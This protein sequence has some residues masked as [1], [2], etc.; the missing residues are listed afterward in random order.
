MPTQSTRP[1]VHTSREVD[2]YPEAAGQSFK[3]GDLLTLAS[4]Q[5]AASAGGAATNLLIA[6]SDATG[7]TNNLT[8]CYRLDEDSRIELNLVGTL[9]ATDV[10]VGYGVSN[11]SGNILQILKSDTT[12]VRLRVV[13][14]N[15]EPTIINGLVGQTFVRVLA[16][17]VGIGTNWA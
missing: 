10:G 7:T 12:N 13:R 11:G 2:H 16:A 17:P 9:A 3:V 15:L 5:I 1:F 8:A 6:A 4:G 14:V